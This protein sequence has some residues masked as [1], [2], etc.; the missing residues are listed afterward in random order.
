MIGIRGWLG[1]GPGLRSIVCWRRS[2]WIVKDNISLVQITNAKIIFLA[3]RYLSPLES[4]PWNLLTGKTP[5]HDRIWLLLFKNSKRLSCFLMTQMFAKESTILSVAPM[6]WLERR[7]SHSLR[8]PFFFNQWKLA[9][10]RR[11]LIGVSLFPIFFS[12][13]VT[14]SHFGLGGL[15]LGPLTMFRPLIWTEI[16]TN[17]KLKVKKHLLKIAD[18]FVYVYLGSAS[19]G[20]QNTIVKWY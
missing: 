1:L 18:D 6:I 2:K 10:D 13:F 16:N 14:D 20:F 12:S 9:K 3:L 15:L 5:D 7:R 4:S 11:S 19:Q 8:N 17:S